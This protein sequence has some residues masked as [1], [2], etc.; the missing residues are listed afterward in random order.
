[1]SEEVDLA[2][3]SLFDY[4]RAQQPHVLLHYQRQISAVGIEYSQRFFT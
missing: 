4:A 1:M 2:I 3:V